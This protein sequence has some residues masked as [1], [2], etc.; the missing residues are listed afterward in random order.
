[1][2]LLDV[3]DVLLD[4]D[5]TMAGLVCTRTPRTLVKG[6]AVDGAPVETPFSGV[7]TPD[8][9]KTFARVPDLTETN[10]IVLVFTAYRL[11]AADPDN[12]VDADLVTTPDGVYTVKQVTPF[13]F[14][15][16]FVAAKCER[17]AR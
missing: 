14:G 3:S 5:F 9:G 8:D 17:V 6:R 2:P 12:N 4:P 13:H 15:A 16:G 10:E 7:V 11:Q 1:M